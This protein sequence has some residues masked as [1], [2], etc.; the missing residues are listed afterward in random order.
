MGGGARGSS[1][2]SWY[3]PGRSPTMCTGHLHN[4]LIAVGCFSFL[5]K[6]SHWLQSTPCCICSL[7]APT[8]G[9]SAL[10]LIVWP[11]RARFGPILLGRCTAYTA[12]LSTVTVP[13]D[14]FA[15]AC[16]C[17]LSGRARDVSP[18]LQPRDSWASCHTH[19]P[20]AGRDR[21]LLDRHENR[22]TAPVEG[23]D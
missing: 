12:T 2:K 23:C 21:R 10:Q 13:G 1:T 6:M 20:P 8:C 19:W 16:R 17:R 15:S 3:T 22:A 14:V 9:V 7:S 11:Y 18:P 5:P 4:P